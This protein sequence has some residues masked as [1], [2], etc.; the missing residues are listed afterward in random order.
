VLGFAVYLIAIIIALNKLDL[1]TTII[2]TIIILFVVVMVLF[3]LFGVNDIFSNF[4]AGLFFRMKKH[5]LVGDII[6]IKDPKRTIDGRV[7]KITLLDMR[8][9][10]GREEIVIIPN[11]LLLRSVITKT[12]KK[13]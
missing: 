11:T 12:R 6:K 9:D 7:E 5:I 8:I 13:K 4:F 1:T 10:T 2:N 3:I